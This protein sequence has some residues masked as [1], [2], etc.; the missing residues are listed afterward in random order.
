VLRA[1]DVISATRPPG[2]G[3]LGQ[4]A[5]NTTAHGQHVDGGRVEAGQNQA[6]STLPTKVAQSCERLV[7]ARP[8]DHHGHGQT[9]HVSACWSDASAGRSSRPASQAATMPATRMTSALGVTPTGRLVMNR[10]WIVV[11]VRRSPWAIIQ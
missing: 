11:G 4:W 8:R 1:K 5:A 10:A 7:V 3:S 6:G 9:N 2:R